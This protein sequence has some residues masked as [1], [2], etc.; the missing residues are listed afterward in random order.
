MC[1]LLTPPS[2]LLS[3]SGRTPLGTLGMRES[4]ERERESVCVCVK[5][6]EEES[7]GCERSEWGARDREKRTK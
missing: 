5:G 2:G 4:E 3:R 6:R 1:L 7:E